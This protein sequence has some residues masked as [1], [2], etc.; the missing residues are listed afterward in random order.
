M[1]LDE[2]GVYIYDD[3]RNYEIEAT[4][5]LLYF[6]TSAIIVLDFI[7]NP[8]EKVMKK[9][10]NSARYYRYHIDHL[11]YYLGQINERFIMKCS[12]N[13]KMKNTKQEHIKL[14]RLNYRF[15][16]TKYPI[17]SQKV[18]R[19][20]IEHLDERNL[21]TIKEYGGVGGFNV[22]GANSDPEMV[23]AIKEKRKYYPYTLDLVDQKVM[24]YN[25][26]SQDKEHIQ[27]EVDLNSL[28]TELES[29]KCSVDLFH[30]ILYC[31]KLK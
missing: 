10:E 26:Q 11:F 9:F 17:L 13:L 31:D 2:L 28:Q 12:K 25:A 5:H 8:E 23:K 21:Q 1:P 14:N 4:Y 22:I 27:F 16:D 7:K 30:D 20:L 29:L 3:N 6:V 19:N 15:E 24:F 18:P